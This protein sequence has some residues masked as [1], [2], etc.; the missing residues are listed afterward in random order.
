MVCT[1]WYHAWQCLKLVIIVGK[2]A[3]WESGYIDKDKWKEFTL[4]QNLSLVTI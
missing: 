1:M 3:N 2:V 4:L